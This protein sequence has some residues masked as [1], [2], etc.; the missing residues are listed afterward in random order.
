MRSESQ[1]EPTRAI[2]PIVRDGVITHYAWSVSYFVNQVATR[3]EGKVSVARVAKETG[4]SLKKAQTHASTLASDASKEFVESLKTAGNVQQTYTVQTWCEH[5][6]T[7]VLSRDADE[8]YVSNSRN[9]VALHVYPTLGNIQL[10]KL[11]WQQLEAWWTDLTT[12]PVAAPVHGKD[13]RMIGHK[14]PKVLKWKTTDHI[15]QRFT[16]ALDAAVARGLMPANPAKTLSPNSR[17]RKAY[18]EDLK[19]RKRWFTVE[20]LKTLRRISKNTALYGPILLQCDLA[21]RIGEA[22]G[23]FITDVDL[24]TGYVSAVRQLARKEDVTGKTSLQLSAPKGDGKRVFIAS[25]ELLDFV[26]QR[27]REEAA[28]APH[29]RCPYIAVNKGKPADPNWVGKAFRMLCETNGIDLAP[30][31]CTHAIRRTILNMMKN[32]P[33]LSKE[34]RAF[35]AGHDDPITTLIYDVDVLTTVQKSEMALAADYVRRHLAA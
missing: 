10:K 16:N 6:F 5:F 25:Q 1:N 9:A 13:G 28:K 19:L 12:K 29:D 20:E 22:C 23:T 34:T 17:Q 30:G 27:Q 18:V 11:N 21:I 33:G 15:R 3:K 32:T 4:F 8:R 7:N 24:A 31:N 26:S 2:R 14:A 35:I